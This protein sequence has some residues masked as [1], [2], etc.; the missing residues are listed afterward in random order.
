VLNAN[1]GTV[2]FGNGLNG[3]VPD[4]KEPIRACFYRYSQLEKGNLPAGHAWA[5]DVDLPPGTKIK[6]GKNLT[7]AVHGRQ[8]EPLEE[9]KLRAREIFQKERVTLTA[10]DYEQLALN[11]PGLRVARVSVLPNFSPKL[12]TLK[13][14]GEITILVLP[15]SPPKDAF[16]NASPPEPSQGFL[17]TVQNHLESRRLVTTNLHVRGPRYVE[18]KVRCNVFLKK[19]ASET[20]VREDI[21]R[22]LKEFLDPVSGGPEKGK[23]WPFGRSV[24]PSEVSQLLAKVPGVDY[25]TGISLNNAKVGEPLKLPYDGL[26]RASSTPHELQLSTFESR[27]RQSASCKG[28]DGCD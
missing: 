10:K 25:V 20:Q 4:L 3:R 21:N 22:A 17:K 5:L 1:E 24:F 7:P 6:E 13:L 15:A 18:V 8:Q 11:T 9:T 23:G 27:G 28:G 26:P 12:P 2:R 16:P 14:P 19:R